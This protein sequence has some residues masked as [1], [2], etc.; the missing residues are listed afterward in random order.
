[1]MI[2][3]HHHGL[4]A[5]VLFAPQSAWCCLGD[6]PNRT[7]TFREAFVW[8]HVFVLLLI[9]LLWNLSHTANFSCFDLACFAT[10]GVLKAWYSKQ[11]SALTAEQRHVLG[12]SVL[13]VCMR[14]VRGTIK[15]C[16]ANRQKVARAFTTHYMYTG[17][18]THVV[19]CR[20]VAQDVSWRLLCGRSLFILSGKKHE[21]YLSRG[22]RTARVTKFR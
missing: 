7:R 1:M 13:Y 4:A 15:K 14:A 18:S 9:S 11:K 17:E 12:V 5:R 22:K 2:D 10:A 21:V 6:R 3:H 16:G 8:W 20:P 19:Y